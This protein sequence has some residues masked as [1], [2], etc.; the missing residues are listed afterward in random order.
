[1]FSVNLRIA[2]RVIETQ[3]TLH[4]NAIS[5]KNIVDH[6][7]KPFQVGQKVTIRL[8]QNK[9]KEVKNRGKLCG[10]FCDKKLDYLKGEQNFLI[11]HITLICSVTFV[12]FFIASVKSREVNSS[13]STILY[14]KKIKF[15]EHF[16][17][18]KSSA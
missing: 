10:N 11:Q 17:V 9:T 15:P 6:L 13:P 4:E 8:T 14:I 2:F 7:V 12:L 3:R 5:L 16:C 18:I 1:M